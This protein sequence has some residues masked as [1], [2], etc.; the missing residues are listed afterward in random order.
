MYTKILAAALAVA[1]LLL[2]GCDNRHYVRQQQVVYAPTAGV[3]VP[4]AP[5]TYDTGRRDQWGGH[6]CAQVQQNSYQGCPRTV[7]GSDC[8]GPNY[9]YQSPA[10]PP[11]MP[12]MSNE[13]FEGVI[14]SPEWKMTT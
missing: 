3:V 7:Y 10:I 9:R 8:S 11:R 5:G 12:R 13:L 4:C 2:A 6:I 1:A 14:L